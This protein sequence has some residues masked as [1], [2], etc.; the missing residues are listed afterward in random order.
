MNHL[1]HPDKLVR[2]YWI[3]WFKR[4]VDISVQLGAKSM[5]V[6]FGIFTHKDNLDPIKRKERRLQNIE[7]WHEIAHYAKKA[8][9]KFLTWEPMSINRE[10][11]ETILETKKLN[12]DV[13]KNSP[14]PFY[15]CLDVDHGDLSSTNPDDTDPYAWLNEFS[16]ISPIIHL[17]QSYQNKGGHWPFTKEHNEKEKIKPYKIIDV[18]IKNNVKDVELCLEL[19]FKERNHLIVL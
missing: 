3:D 9:L 1:A 7:G 12:E 19:S 16:S 17:K 2:Q 14:I 4:F 6:I 11:G 10:Q 18:L 5:G 8:G 13:N 15:I